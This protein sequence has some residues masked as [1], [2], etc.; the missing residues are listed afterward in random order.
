MGAPRRTCL[1][2]VTG[3]PRNPHQRTLPGR[4]CL[5]PAHPTRL[6]HEPPSGALGGAGTRQVGRAYRARGGKATEPP[7]N[8]LLRAEA[9]QKFSARSWSCGS[10]P[11]STTTSATS[12]G[13][14]GPELGGLGAIR[15]RHRPG[16]RRGSP[17]R[18]P[19]IGP[20]R[21]M[22][23]WRTTRTRSPSFPRRSSAD[24]PLR[25]PASRACGRGGSSTRTSPLQTRRP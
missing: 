8:P 19:R 9:L 12:L 22:C 5:P 14:P 24:D 16:I 6:S 11:M 20:T 25:S 1:A 15:P 10:L 18:P 7:P 3:L 21:R 13:G 23:T 4:A 2:L 17:R